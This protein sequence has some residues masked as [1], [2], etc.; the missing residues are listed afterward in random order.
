MNCKSQRDCFG[1]NKLRQYEDLRGVLSSESKGESMLVPATN[2][3]LFRSTSCVYMYTVLMR[4]QSFLIGRCLCC[5]PKGVGPGTAVRICSNFKSVED[6]WPRRRFITN[7]RNWKTT[8]HEPPNKA[9]YVECFWYW[10]IGHFSFL[11]CPVPFCLLPAQNAD[12]WPTNFC[13]SLFLMDRFR[14]P[15]KLK[16]VF[17]E[18]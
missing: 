14:T 13:S 11:S 12:L 9:I 2:P 18:Q 5:I 7:H 15:T 10:L 17:D 1:G 8:S 3:V 4:T 16:F 6:H